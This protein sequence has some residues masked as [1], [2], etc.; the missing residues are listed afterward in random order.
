MIVV[1]Y[2]NVII[3]SRYYSIHVSYTPLVC[4]PDGGSVSHYFSLLIFY[5]PSRT[6]LQ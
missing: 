6:S 5:L 3:T 2:I 4:V 1:R